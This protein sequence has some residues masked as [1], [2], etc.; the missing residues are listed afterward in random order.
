MQ[1]SLSSF[2]F[3][4]FSQAW[5]RTAADLSTPC[6]GQAE[7]ALTEDSDH[8]FFGQ[9]LS[10]YV[11]SGKIGPTQANLV[12]YDRIRFSPLKLL[13]YLRQL[14]D[15]SETTLRTWAPA[16]ALALLINAYNALLIAMVAHYDPSLSV[17]DI[18]TPEGSVWKHAFLN[19]GGVKV[20]A[21]MI[22]HDMIRG[23]NGGWGYAKK[24][25]DNVQGLIHAGVVCASLS[26]P[27]LQMEPFKGSTVVEQLTNATKSWLA[28]PTK[29]SFA[30]SRGLSVS[31]IFQW[32][33]ADFVLASG[34]VHAH[35][36]KYKPDS[37]AAVTDNLTI[38]YKT[39]DWYLNK[40]NGTASLSSNYALLSGCRWLS[41]GLALS[42]SLL[43]AMA[44]HP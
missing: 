43:S 30:P 22:E 34:S 26:C 21:D 27:D 37:W 36:Q 14:C 3:A 12:D 1:L 42:C 35:L 29:N 19:L 5:V 10:T 44:W 33:E 20:S 8:A 17:K 11:S 31:K 41:I 23:Q 13:R 15:V 4:L 24:I 2:V 7:A 9:V 32:Y 6:K 38:S 40:L 25:G 28:N 18:S 39:Y 16:N